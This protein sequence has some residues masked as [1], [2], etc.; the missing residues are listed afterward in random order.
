MPEIAVRNIPPSLTRMGR[1]EENE[2]VR[3][4]FEV[5]I[6][7]NFFFRSTFPFGL[8]YFFPL[9]KKKLDGSVQIAILSGY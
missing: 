4:P 6:S 7:E 8:G 5:I 1:D 9:A 2:M 3:V